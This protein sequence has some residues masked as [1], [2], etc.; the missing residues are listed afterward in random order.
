MLPQT[1]RAKEDMET[2][3]FKWPADFTLETPFNR[4][5]GGYDRTVIH[6]QRGKDQSFADQAEE[7]AALGYEVEIFEIRDS[8]LSVTITKAPQGRVIRY[9]HESGDDGQAQ[10]VTVNRNAEYAASHGRQCPEG[11]RQELGDALN[12]PPGYDAED[13]AEAAEPTPEEIEHYSNMGYEYDADHNIFVD[14]YGALSERQ[15]SDMTIEQLRRH[16]RML[17]DMEAHYGQDSNN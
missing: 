12:T 13:D 7:I 16:E 14:A 15:G 6:P 17:A 11:E 2:L 4:S 9:E 5:I 3:G 8:Y 1:V 10:E